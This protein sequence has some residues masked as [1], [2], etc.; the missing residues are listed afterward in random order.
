LLGDD[1]IGAPGFSINHTMAIPGMESTAADP[2]SLEY[3]GLDY[4]K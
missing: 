2:D 1:I 4:G 3:D